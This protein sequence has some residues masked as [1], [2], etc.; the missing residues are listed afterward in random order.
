[1]YVQD[2]GRTSKSTLRILVPP[3]CMYSPRHPFKLINLGFYGQA[4]AS[5]Q[6]PENFNSLHPWLVVSRCLASGDDLILTHSFSRPAM[7]ILFLCLSHMQALNELH[8]VIPP[9]KNICRQSNAHHH[10]TSP[11]I[12]IL[13]KNRPRGGLVGAQRHFY[14]M[15]TKLKFP[16]PH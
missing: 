6:S 2:S 13:I 11:S 14:W 3:G 12:T 8:S 7:R 10:N 15:K 5:S 4:G 16:F 9:D 1:M